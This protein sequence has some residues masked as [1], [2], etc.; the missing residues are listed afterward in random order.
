MKILFYFSGTS[1]LASDVCDYLEQYSA[2]F[3]QNVMRIYID[4]CQ[5]QTVGNGILSPN[6]EIVA[7]NIEATFTKVDSKVMFDLDEFKRRFTSTRFSIINGNQ[8]HKAYAIRPE[9]QPDVITSS[10]D[11]LTKI[12]VEN[13]CL[14]GFS[15]GAVETFAVAKKLDK[16]DVPMHI[17]ANQPVSGERYLQKTKT[18]SNL[19]E[20]KNICSATVMVASHNRENGFIHNNFF[21]SMVPKFPDSQKSWN[22]MEVPYQHHA[23][24]D[25][26]SLV[27][28]VD[29]HFWNALLKN[30]YLSSHLSLDKIRSS[31]TQGYAQHLWSFTPKRYKQSVHTESTRIAKEPL[32]FKWMREEL[33]NNDNDKELLH[34]LDNLDDDKIQALYQIN[35]L[36]SIEDPERYKNLRNFIIEEDEAKK[37]KKEKFV[38]IVNLMTEACDYLSARTR[39]SKRNSTF[40]CFLSLFKDQDW[41][42]KDTKKSIAI[43]ENSTEYQKNSLSTTYDF[44][45]LDSPTPEQHKEFVTGIKEAEYTFQ[46]NALLEERDP[47]RKLLKYISNFITSTIF[48][49][50]SSLFSKDSDSS[51]EQKKSSK[52]N[53]FYFLPNRSVRMVKDIR[54]EVVD[55]VEEVAPRQALTY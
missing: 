25:N 30:N 3:D 18:Y 16:F 32:Y 46:K 9:G 31:F 40:F 5:D 4:G 34:V 14:A 10:S 19:T 28:P 13:I 47:A 53:L 22:I 6:L 15:R 42:L 39:Y 2:F 12:Q 55:K 23:D 36:Y 1:C 26:N 11:K 38:E 37:E 49:I 24:A 17:I 7:K 54:K 33:G 52:N 50:G 35:K 29:Y 45:M 41:E 27:T 51:T 21:K 48:T 44:L 43:A 20:C 8:K